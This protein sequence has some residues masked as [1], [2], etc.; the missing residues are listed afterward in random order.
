M[1]VHWTPGTAKDKPAVLVQLDALRKTE[2]EARWA[3][4]AAEEQYDRSHDLDDLVVVMEA[5]DKF[6]AAAKAT[7]NWWE[8]ARATVT[9]TGRALPIEDWQEPE[10]VFRAE[11]ARQKQRKIGGGKR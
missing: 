4:E 11:V 10:D 6:K 3:L 9:R 2:R 7:A 8:R 1:S 5:R